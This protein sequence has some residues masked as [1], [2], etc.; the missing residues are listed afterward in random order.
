MVAD[1]YVAMDELEE[2]QV[3]KIRNEVAS[4]EGTT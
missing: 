3:K 1:D 4:G 2:D